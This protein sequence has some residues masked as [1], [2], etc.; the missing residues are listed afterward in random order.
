MY[1]LKALEQVESYEQKLLRA[2]LNFY[3]A[4][5]KGHP[6]FEHV[7]TIHIIDDTHCS[8][9]QFALP[10]F[11]YRI[12]MMPTTPMVLTPTLMRYDKKK[13][14]LRPLNINEIDNIIHHLKCSEPFCNHI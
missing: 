4:F 3:T 12:V 8:G 2:N 6:D 13:R 5:T 9:T 1:A 7:C 11:E 10:N 14:T